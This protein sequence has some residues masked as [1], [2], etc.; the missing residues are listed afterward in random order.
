MDRIVIR[1]SSSPKKVK[2]RVFDALVEEDKVF[3]E[4]KNGK[5][6]EVIALSDVLTQITE[7]QKKR[8][9]TTEP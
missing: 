2:P 1:N 4:V 9:T 8:I 6:C 7:Y 3:F 5:A